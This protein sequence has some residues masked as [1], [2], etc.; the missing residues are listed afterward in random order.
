MKKKSAIKIHLKLKN[1]DGSV[2]SYCSSKLRRIYSIL[3]E[4]KFKKAYLRVNYEVGYN[5]GEYSNI[6]DL[7][8]ALSVF[9]EKSL[10]K[11]LRK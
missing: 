9:T 8:M 11:Y 5:D 1:N 2:K 3:Q 10:I 4:A 7:K 6:T